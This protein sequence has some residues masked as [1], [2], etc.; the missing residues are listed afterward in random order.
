M[1]KRNLKNLALKKAVISNLNNVKG[2]EWIP[3]PIIRTQFEGCWSL[4][5]HRTCETG[6][7]PTCDHSYR[8]CPVITADNC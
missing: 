6:L 2:G 8:I 7:H 1:K 5:G 3:I 4:V